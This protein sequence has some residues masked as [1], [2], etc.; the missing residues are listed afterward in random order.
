MQGFASSESYSQVLIKSYFL[1]ALVQLQCPLA[2]RAH[3]SSR[4]I[5]PSAGPTGVENNFRPCLSQENTISPVH[6]PRWAQRSPET[7]H[8][9]VAFL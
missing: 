1:L 2:A 3:N 4:A 6:G 7:Q 5:L 8:L 9:C